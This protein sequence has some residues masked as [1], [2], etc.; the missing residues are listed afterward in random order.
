MTT[1]DRRTLLK[2]VAL[3]PITALPLKTLECDHK[4]T[5]MMKCEDNS[6][7]GSR[8]VIAWEYPFVCSKCGNEKFMSPYDRNSYV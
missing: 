4:Y 1:M 5:P 8:A 6:P 2:S 7:G 3:V